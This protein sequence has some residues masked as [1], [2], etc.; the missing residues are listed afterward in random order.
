MLED[1]PLATIF[2][3]TSTFNIHKKIQNWHPNPGLYV[4]SMMHEHIWCD[5]GC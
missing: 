4:S 1:H 3:T 5:P 2:W